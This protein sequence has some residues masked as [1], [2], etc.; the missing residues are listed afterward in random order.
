LIVGVILGF[1]F[2]RWLFLKQ[3]K[4]IEKKYQQSVRQT[5]QEMGSFFGR[6]MKEEDLNRITAQIGGETEKKETNPKKPKPK[7]KK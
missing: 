7:K 6:K 4:E 1:L 5:Y 2:A 3:K